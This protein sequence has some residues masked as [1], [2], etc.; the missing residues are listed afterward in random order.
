[1][2]TVG[3]ARAATADG[4][5]AGSQGPQ[6]RTFTVLLQIIPGYE[7][8]PLYYCASCAGYYPFQHFCE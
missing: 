7:Q 3:P 8:Q 5:Q 6:R 4:L 1:M 2:N